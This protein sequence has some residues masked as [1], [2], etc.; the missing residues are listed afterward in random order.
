MKHSSLFLIAA[1]IMLS[2]MPISA[3]WRYGV[4]LGGEFTRPYRDSQLLGC[5]AVYGGS[6][7]SGGLTLEWQMPTCGF[8]TGVSLLYQRR[9]INEE[10]PFYGSKDKLELRKLG[11][12]FLALPID[13][14]YKF[15]LSATKNLV[16]PYLFSGPDLALRLGKSQNTNAFHFGWNFGAG[17]DI[18]NFLQL[19]G[20]YRLGISEISKAGECRDSG[21]F[22]SVAILFDF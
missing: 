10:P 19:S 16:A 5:G 15:F 4:R 7:F 21:G 22:V 1:F 12:D 3:Q 6:G 14:K 2:V 18:I 20:G 17:L 9:T 13:L 11:G 8:A